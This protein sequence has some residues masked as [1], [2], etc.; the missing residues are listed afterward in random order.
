MSKIS[1]LSQLQWV[2]YPDLN[3]PIPVVGC[4]EK[5]QR[6]EKKRLRVTKMHSLYLR[7]LTELDRWV[8]DHDKLPVADSL[9]VS[10]ESISKY[11]RSGGMNKKMKVQVLHDYKGGYQD[12]EDKD[13]VGYFPAKSSHQ[14]YLQFPKLVDEFVYFSHHRISVPP[15]SWVHH[16][17][18]NGITCLGTVIFEK[19][20]DLDL[21]VLKEQDG[22][23]FKYVTLLA[24]LAIH[25]KF[26]G[27]LINIETEFQNRSL[28]LE[29][30]K[31]LLLLRSELR[32][33]N[34]VSKVVWYDAFIPEM[35]KI[36]YENGISELNYDLYKNSDSMLTNYWWGT[37]QLRNNTTLAGSRADLFVGVDVWGRGMR[38]GGGGMDTYKAVKK[39]SD[40]NQN[41]GLFAPAWDFEYLPKCD[42]EL[43]DNKFFNEPLDKSI[44]YLTGAYNSPVYTLELG[45]FIFY[46][47]F[48]QGR[49]DN[50]FEK[51]IPL[52]LDKWI[53][54]SL[55]SEI[56]DI[57]YEQQL[58][59]NEY[60]N[61]NL[62]YD[63]AFQLGA[64]LQVDFTQPGTNQQLFGIDQLIS[65]D[66][67]LKMSYKFLKYGE[68]NIVLHYYINRHVKSVHRV[69]EGDIKIPLQGDLSEWV[70]LK[71]KFPIPQHS[72]FEQ[73]FLESISIEYGDGV[74]DW[75]IVNAETLSI[76]IGEISVSTIDYVSPT[77]V[78]S[79]GIQDQV[80]TWENDDL[81][82]YWNILV[83][84]RFAG[85][86]VVP[87]FNISPS[88]RKVRVDI[89][90]RDGGVIL[91]D[92]VSLY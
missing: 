2:Q 63:D 10:R 76:L 23:H 8:D 42:F 87:Y 68:I 56:P 73:C 38:F 86:A 37:T 75:V 77:K 67:S 13:P 83:D 49:G 55:I 91:G 26:D 3:S 14:Y 69:R 85:T 28:A 32:L 61:M 7:D 84:D 33:T 11:Q 64:S 90:S 58:N 47:N 80:L 71:E 29:I 79:L 5:K 57:Y 39:L 34:P 24:L 20:S 22:I 4:N 19:G 74:E 88:A 44:L 60:F 25:Y 36:K 1:F 81:V 21:I 66:M 62:R 72:K 27:Y 45:K 31:F 30:P 16:C 46:T 54:K 18:R 12:Q 51:G 50:F 43:N 65:N 15:I 92:S 9:R 17:H 52:L 70:S 35:N 89:V 59:A 48:S 6:K 53:N 82:L 40:Y 78:R 41:C